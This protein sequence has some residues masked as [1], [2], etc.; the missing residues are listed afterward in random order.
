[1]QD[2]RY[3]AYVGCLSRLDV[4]QQLV[5]LSFGHAS[6]LHW[7]LAIEQI[8]FGAQQFHAASYASYVVFY[9]CK[10]HQAMG[11]QSPV[12]GWG[13][14]VVVFSLAGCLH[15]ACHPRYCL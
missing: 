6:V 5:E 7:P 8:P 12:H 3:V 9:V 14:W 10:H 15:F 13:C 4:E 2:D 1:L 11:P